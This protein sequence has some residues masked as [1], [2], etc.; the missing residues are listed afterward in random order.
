MSQTFRAV[1]LFFYS[2][3]KMVSRA[4]VQVMHSSNSLVTNA[5]ILGHHTFSLRGDLVLF[6]PW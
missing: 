1:T 6:T 3:T 5:S 2:A 4:A